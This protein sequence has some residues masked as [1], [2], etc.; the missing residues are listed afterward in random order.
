MHRI[1]HGRDG[2]SEK[3]RPPVFMMHGLLGAS[4]NFVLLEPDY[5]IAHNLV[6]AGFDVWLGNAR[7]TR[8][9]RH[10]VT[11]NPDG[12]VDKFKYWDFSWEQIGM[13]DIPAMTDYVRENTGFKKIH[14]IGH[15]QGGTVFFVMNAIRPEYNDK[16]ATAH[17]LAPAGFKQYFPNSLLSAAALFTNTIYKSATNRGFLEVD[18]DVIDLI[19]NNEELTDNELGTIINEIEDN[20]TG[21]NM[22]DMPSMFGGAALKQIAHYGQCIRSGNFQRWDFGLRGNREVYGT[23][24]PPLFDMSKMTVNTTLHYALAD[25]LVGPQDILDMERILPNA[26]SRLVAD[27]AFTHTSF[28][29]DT[30][31]KE[32]VT[33][34]VIEQLKSVEIE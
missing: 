9:S 29:S 4:S 14:Y 6:D 18:L 7:G 26:I 33:G 2:P 25:N 22:F 21:T 24:T 13:Y 30:N 8:D 16:F 19:R 31:A 27:D 11:L 3:V 15:S 20:E 28:V 32:L 1:P 34:Y 12:E 10:H 23:L 17:L 5:S